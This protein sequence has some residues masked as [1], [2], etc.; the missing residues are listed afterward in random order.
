VKN[1]IKKRAQ[2]QEKKILRKRKCKYVFASPRTARL[3]APPQQNLGRANSVLREVLLRGEAWNPPR[4]NSV[5][6]QLDAKG[7]PR[8]TEWDP[9]T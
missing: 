7:R 3:E 6:R 2:T 5:P 1:P 9:T 8:L 4:L